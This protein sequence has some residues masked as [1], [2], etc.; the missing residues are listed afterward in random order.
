MTQKSVATLGSRAILGSFY[1]ALA[2][3]PGAAWIDKISFYSNSD[4]E[5]EEYRWIG[6]VPQMREWI[7]GRQAKGFTTNG[8]TI[9]N[10]KYEATIELSVDDIRR[11]KTRQIER[12]I[13]ELAQRTNSHW[14]SLLSTL[15]QNGASTLCYD[16]QYFFDTDHSEGDSGTQDNDLSVDISALPAAVHGS[17][18][19]PSAQEMMLAIF[20]AISQ[21]QSFKDDQGEPMNE[22]A[23]EFVVMVPISLQAA[24]QSAVSSMTF[25]GGETNVLAAAGFKVTVAPNPRLTWTDQFAVFRA[26]GMAAAFIRQEEEGVTTSALAE[27]SDHAVLMDTHQYGVKALRNVGYGFWQHAC[28]V[29]MV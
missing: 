5:S 22:D 23:M 4:Q 6:Q 13:A 24:A 3:N 20:Q 14:A 8:I 17:T 28:L 16:G 1:K 25:G 9:K 21:I 26:D 15:I 18:T 29:T 12:R 2:A 27:N 7:G 10:K 19:A 11:D